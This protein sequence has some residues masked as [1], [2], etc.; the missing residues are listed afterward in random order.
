[1]EIT[2]DFVL[3][4]EA[5]QRTI[6]DIISQLR[7]T[8]DEVSIDN[9]GCPT[10]KESQGPDW[11]EFPIK[12]ADDWPSEKESVDLRPPRGDSLTKK[13]IKNEGNRTENEWIKDPMGWLERE[14]AQNRLCPIKAT[15]SPGPNDLYT[16]WLYLWFNHE[17]QLVTEAWARKKKTAFREA[18]LDM[19]RKVRRLRELEM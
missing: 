15:Y 13:D 8:T 4:L 18:A 9:I 10:A 19:V 5:L 3:A 12:N 6:S 11:I 7:P 2:N 17:H 16:V 1:M 14:Y